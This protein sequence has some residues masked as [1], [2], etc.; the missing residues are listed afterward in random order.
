MRIFRVK[1]REPANLP[2]ISR[3]I[4]NY[5][6]MDQHNIPETDERRL[7]KYDKAK[8]TMLYTMTT[9][10]KPGPESKLI[11]DISSKFLPNDYLASWSLKTQQQKN[12][13]SWQKY[14]SSLKRKSVLRNRLKSN[15]T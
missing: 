7:S 13:E 6:N 9:S 3:D 5:F 1:S 10:Q 12:N 11:E 4:P 2:R 15:N 14:I 8:Y